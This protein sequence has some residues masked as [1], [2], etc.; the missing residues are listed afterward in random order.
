MSMWFRCRNRM[1]AL[2]AGALLAAFLLGGTAYSQETKVPSVGVQTGDGKEHSRGV[3]G[4]SLPEPESDAQQ[5]AGTPTVTESE[6]VAEAQPTAVAPTAA[7]TDTKADLRA[8]IKVLRDDAARGRLIEELERSMPLDTAVGPVSGVPGDTAPPDTTAPE[9]VEGTVPEHST[10]GHGIAVKSQEAADRISA[11][12]QNFYN[13]LLATE[14]RLGGIAKL[15]MEELRGILL[16]LIVVLLVT[17]G[18]YLTL[19]GLMRIALGKIIRRIEITT[20]TMKTMV[21]LLFVVLSGSVV[22]VGWVAGYLAGIMVLEPTGEITLFQTLYLNAFLLVGLI[23]IAVRTPLAPKHSVFRALPM[24]DATAHFWFGRISIIVAILGYGQMV[25]VPVV[26]E[27]VSIFTGRATSVLIY[28]VVLLWT[29]TIVIRKRHQLPAYVADRARRYGGGLTLRFFASASRF[30][31]WAVVAYLLLLFFIDVTQAGDLAPVIIA[32][33]KILAAFAIG[34]TIMTLAHLASSRGIHLPDEVTRNLPLLE[35]RLNTFAPLFLRLLRLAILVIVVTYSLHVVGFADVGA[36][37]ETSFGVDLTSTIFSV[38]LIV[39]VAFVIWLALMSWVDFRLN[40]EENQFASTRKRTLLTL[41]RN[42]ATIVIIAISVMFV[43]SEIGI[44]IAP[45]VASAGVLGLAIGFGAQKMVQDIITG[46]FIQFENAINVGDVVTLAGTTGTVD[47]L[48]IRSVSL[49]DIEGTYHIIPFSSVD[50]VSNYN[51]GFAYHVADI[52]IAYREDIDDAK[53]L[54][55]AAFDDLREMSDHK[56]SILDELE[57]FGVNELGDSAVVL[58]ARIKTVPGT[59]WEIGRAYRE[60]VK[61]RFDAARV[62]IPFPQTT[63]WFGED[64]AGE[65]PAARMRLEGSVEASPTAPPPASDP[66]STT[67]RE[68]QP[69]RAVADTSERD[70]D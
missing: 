22:L 14:R 70:D 25:L 47:K 46:I 69:T 52:G 48:T 57:W 28:V 38:S 39:V 37:L 8:L 19:N 9:S 40:S 33:A 17:N 21:A 16:E 27:A 35:S 30:W 67:S 24:S 56:Q 61:K 50:A 44:N 36:W 15:D 20:L 43:L 55:L 60:L 31:H 4:N 18:V 32:T 13:S 49:R 23:K 41:F 64:R 10:I 66:P 51:R 2:M 26:N 62:E 63:I 68:P 34:F 58:R 11:H 3:T 12:V 53:A 5:D 1:P 42:A 59:Q 65:A 45:L 54:M 7:D 29:M 6:P